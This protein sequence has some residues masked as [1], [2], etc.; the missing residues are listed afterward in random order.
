MDFKKSHLKQRISI[1]TIALLLT[2]VPSIS[3]GLWW[4]SAEFKNKTTKKME[5]LEKSCAKKNGNSFLYL[6]TPN[7]GK[8]W[9]YCPGDTN[10]LIIYTIEKGKIT[11]EEN[12]PYLKPINWLDSF[13][14]DISSQVFSYKYTFDAPTFRGIVE[15]NRI[16]GGDAEEDNADIFLPSLTQMVIFVD[17][18]PQRSFYDNLIRRYQKSTRSND[19]PKGFEKPIDHDPFFTNLS[20]DICDYVFPEINVK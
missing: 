16:L 13:R 18:F 14:S 17:S 20:R 1:V 10:H 6:I 4:G 2:V 8:V 15:R 3:G 11:S 12:I 5:K 7:K 19:I 9:T